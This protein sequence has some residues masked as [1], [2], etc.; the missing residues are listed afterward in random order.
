VRTT[1]DSALFLEQRRQGNWFVETKWSWNPV[2]SC[3]GF[4]KEATLLD[5]GGLFQARN[6][7][8]QVTSD[9]IWTLL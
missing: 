5:L 9:L 6:S 1:S 3:G 8:F 7:R 4:G 2:G